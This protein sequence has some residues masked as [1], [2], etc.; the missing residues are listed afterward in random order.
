M[1]ARGSL[2]RHLMLGVSAI[3]LLTLVL[4]M[5]LVMQH[6]RR[7]VVAETQA[8]T[9]LVA[10][11]IA[12]WPIMTS[13]TQ[14]Q[15]AITQLR[16]AMRSSRHLCAVT[17]HD[18]GPVDCHSSAV[19]TAPHW[20]VQGLA[21]PSDIDRVQLTLNSVDGPI[22]LTVIADTRYEIDEAWR[23]SRGI[24]VFIALFALGVVA[25]VALV[26]R[27]VTVLL[28]G[29]T[30]QVQRMALGDYRSED[31]MTAMPRE[32]LPLFRAVSGLRHS[33]DTA[34]AEN[35]QLARQCLEAQ[36]RERHDVA[37][38]LHDEVGQHLS[39]AE[40]QLAVAARCTDAG[41]R[42]HA[43]EQVRD[44]LRAIFGSV[45]GLLA[46]LRPAAIDSVGLL[47][48]LEQL[49]VDWR[50][51]DRGI[52]L[53]VS[54]SG[55]DRRLD[56]RIGIHVYRVAQEA[57][58]NIARHA[59]G[60]RHAVLHCCCTSAGAVDLVVCDDGPGLGAQ[61]CPGGGFGLRGM[62]ERAASIDADFAV[63]TGRAWSTVIRLRRV[64]SAAIG[65]APSGLKGAVTQG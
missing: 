43:T 19:A 59:G 44:S 25:M 60:A 53:T 45:H 57:L 48:A 8:S 61:P 10:E 42:M 34:T 55:E 22:P 24:M 11:L 27:K 5:L 1:S 37:R 33:L 29:M 39:A 13:A 14:T 2:Q 6:A 38:E 40:A 31:R 18:S 52:A 46:R 65:T 35:R 28:H 32:L 56:P 3:A 63:E 15:Q 23:E 4:S 30:A 64:E 54:L 58:T 36:E 51:E 49:A 16:A 62:R 21:L 50:A 7:S 9:A 47:A 41:G 26:F 17:L 12:A 20:F